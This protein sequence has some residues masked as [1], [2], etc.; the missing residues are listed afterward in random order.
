MMGPLCVWEGENGIYDADAMNTC[1]EWRDRRHQM[2]IGCE[3]EAIS[4]GVLAD[5]SKEN[6]PVL[7]RGASY[8]SKRLQGPR[9]RST[10]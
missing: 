5:F 10:R 7:F 2:P 6:R 9:T 8:F 4:R 3:F 1:H